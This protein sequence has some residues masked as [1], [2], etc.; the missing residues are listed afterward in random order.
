MTR[1]APRWWGRSGISRRRFGGGPR[2]VRAGGRTEAWGRDRRGGGAEARRA[3][4][5]VNSRPQRR[6]RGV[7]RVPRRGWAGG[8]RPGTRRGRGPGRRG[9]AGRRRRRGRGLGGRSKSGGPRS[10]ARQRSVGV[11]RVRCLVRV[12]PRG[13]TRPPPVP[14]PAG[15]STALGRPAPHPRLTQ[16][17]RRSARPPARRLRPPPVA[18][19]LH[20]PRRPL[21]PGA[22][23]GDPRGTAEGRRTRGTGSQPPRAL[24]RP[25]SWV[26]RPRLFAVGGAY[27]LGVG[28]HPAHLPES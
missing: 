8:W 22:A 17:P 2:G 27:P 10:R 11:G 14:G 19:L 18:V 1:A 9:V 21:R 25:A 5:G 12:T 23:R 16:P 6:H 3:R 15:G 26:P 20:P 24:P 7:A 13:P 28:R 4:N